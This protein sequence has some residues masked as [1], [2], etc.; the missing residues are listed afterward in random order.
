MGEIA[1]T[2]DGAVRDEIVSAVDAC[3][4]AEL[5]TVGGDYMG[6]HWLAAFAL[7]A[8]TRAGSGCHIAATPY[9][10]SEYPLG[11]IGGARP[12]CRRLKGRPR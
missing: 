7:L 2:T 10:K 11:Q 8:P 6:E 9:H 1:L 12:K 3:V 5:G 4:A